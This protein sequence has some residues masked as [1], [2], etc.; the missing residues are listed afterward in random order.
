VRNVFF[1]GIMISLLFKTNRTVF[2]QLPSVTHGAMRQPNAVTVS[3][4]TNKR[5]CNTQLG[6]G[7]GRCCETTV[8]ASMKCMAAISDGYAMAKL[9]LN[10]AS[11]PYA[12]IHYTLRLNTLAI[13]LAELFA[14]FL[15]MIR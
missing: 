1:G 11:T 9:D 14:I 7:V 6:V 15:H 3:V 2:D 5:K 10:Y 8:Y 13:E 12:Y 4:E